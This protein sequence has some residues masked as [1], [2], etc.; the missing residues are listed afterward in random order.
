MAI[1]GGTGSTAGGLKQYRIY[2]LLRGLHSE[3]RRLILPRQTISDLD[4]WVGEQRRFLSDGQ[5][6][7]VGV[8]VFLYLISLLAGTLIFC[9]YGN[10]L[11]E[12]LFEFASAL[13]TVGLSSGIISA[14]APEGILWAGIAGMI[15]GR[16][17][18][19]VIFVGVV[20]MATD[21]P[22]LSGRGSS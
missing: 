18:F 15:F 16:L 6:R 13:G 14:D 20:R 1:G 8:F 19:F 3:L 21:L 2:V 10:P 22:L 17:E 9:A 12:S 7:Q 11:R 4:I 5:F